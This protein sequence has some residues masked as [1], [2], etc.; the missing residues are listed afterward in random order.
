MPVKASPK[1]VTELRDYMV[2]RLKNLKPCNLKPIGVVPRRNW[3]PSS[4]MDEGFFVF[5]NGYARAMG[6]A[7]LTRRRAKKICGGERCQSPSL[8]SSG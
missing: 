7:N 5:P 2:P 3:N 6:L 1:W 8:R 4:L